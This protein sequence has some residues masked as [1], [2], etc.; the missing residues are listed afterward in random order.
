MSHASKDNT[1]VKT[2]SQTTQAALLLKKQLKSLNKTPI[3]GFSA[4]LVNDDNI[5]EWQF[6]IIGPPDTLYEGGFFN[7]TLTFPKDY[8]QGPPT[9]KFTTQI[10]HPNVYDDGKVCISILHPPGDDEF[11]YEKAAERWNPIHTVES[12]I[13]SVITMLAD[14]NDQSPANIDAAKQW[15]EQPDAFKKKVKNC[16]RRSQDA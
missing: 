4:G 16:V 2:E 11:G 3:E 5:Y 12:I 1:P 8:P 14:P 6:C 15:R 9:M 13:L 10:W 7:G